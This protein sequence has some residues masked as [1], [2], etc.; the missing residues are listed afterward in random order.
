MTRELA[1]NREAGARDAMLRAALASA[2][3]VRS[4]VL[5]SPL[6][7]ST[8]LIPRLFSA[9]AP[10]SLISPVGECCSTAC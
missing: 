7:R 3:D 4:H 10:M 1:P 6:R 2:H 9:S 5:P 8:K